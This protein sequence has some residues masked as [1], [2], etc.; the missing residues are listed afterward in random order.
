MSFSRRKLTGQAGVAAGVLAVV[1][2]VVAV[3]NFGNVQLSGNTIYNLKIG[4]NAYVEPTTTFLVSPAANAAS[5]R[6]VLKLGG[7]T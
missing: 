1:V 7:G 2:A 3:A 4:T 6:V 5:E